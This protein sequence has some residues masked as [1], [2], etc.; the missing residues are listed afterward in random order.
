MY[1]AS[2]RATPNRI[3]LKWIMPSQVKACNAPSSCVICT[4]VLLCSAERQFIADISEQHIGPI[5][6]GQEIQKREKSMTAIG[7]GGAG[8]SM[9]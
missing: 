8:F 6:K 4:L 1:K 5:F 3:A 9:I 7:G 2:K